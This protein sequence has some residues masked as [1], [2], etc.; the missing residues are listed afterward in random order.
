MD[1]DP[2]KHEKAVIV[3]Q[4]MD[5]FAP[6]LGIPADIA[7]SA[8]DMPWSRRPSEAGNRPPV[9]ECQEFQVLPDW[10]CVAQVV[11]LC[12]QSVMKFLKRSASD[13]LYGYGNKRGNV[14]FDRT[15]IDCNW[16]LRHRM[17]AACN[18]LP[19]RQLD[20]SLGLKAQ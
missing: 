2:G 16:F 12:E 1:I 3:G 4:K 7:I 5:V 19:W 10:F 14:G 15:L 11:E 20:V 17:A 13:L 9:R 8:S 18:T 6:S